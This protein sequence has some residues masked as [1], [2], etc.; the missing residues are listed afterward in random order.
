MTNTR[1][2]GVPSDNRIAGLVSTLAWDADSLEY[3]FPSS[4]SQYGSGYSRSDLLP[5]FSEFTEAQKEAA[6]Q[7][8]D[9][10]SFRTPNAAEGMTVEGF[11]KLDI[12]TGSATSAELRFGNTSASEV[13]T[14]TGYYPSALDV[15]GDAWFGGGGQSPEVGNSDYKTILHE[16]G[17]TLGLKH[18]H[19][20]KDGRPAVPEKWDGFEYTVMTYRSETG[21]SLAN[22]T[23]TWGAP[24]T[25]MMLDIAAL[26]YLYG[27][28]FTTNADN[29]VYKWK[30]DSSNTIVNG[31]VALNPGGDRIFATIWDGGGKDT[32]DLSA[33]DTGVKVD[34]NPGKASLFSKQQAAILD[35]H[36]GDLASGNIYNALQYEGDKRSLIEKALGGAGD[37]RLIGNAVANVLKGGAGR[38]ALDGGKGADKLIGGNGADK[39]IGGKGADLLGGGDG[40]DRFVFKD[41]NETSGTAVD[42]IV[43]SGGV[44][45]FQGAG[46][47]GGDRIDL[48]RIDADE[49]RSGDQDFSFGNFNSRRLDEP[50]RLWV[51]EKDGKTYVRGTVDNDKGPDFE[52][53]IKDGNGVDASDYGAVDFIL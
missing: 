13:S 22:R 43:A 33:Y 41:V 38:D 27:A 23:E 32:Y 9:A 26:Q 12:S 6:A 10:D 30:P 45:A 20:E 44:K 25:F 19:E 3:A 37:D 24:Q 21:G 53:I 31:Q 46:R 42:K 17:H 51:V 7:A 50:G 35:K 40:D 36:E 2:P 39:L 14:A 4:S 28:D 18:A 49:T 1:T 16:T 48:S 5:S 47:T 52:I 29:T 8:L 11:T 15:G 34:L